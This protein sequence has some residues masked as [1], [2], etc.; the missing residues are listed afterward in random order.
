MTPAQR[1]AL[2]LRHL[3]QLARA[4]AELR[5]A[6]A[7]TL[8]ALQL[9]YEAKDATPADQQQATTQANDDVDAQWLLLLLLLFGRR[10]DAAGGAK[11]RRRAAMQEYAARARPALLAVVHHFIEG[12]RSGADPGELVRSTSILV[13]RTNVIQAYN[14]GAF[15]GVN[16]GAN[17]DATKTWLS[18][19]DDR[20]RPTHKVADGQTVALTAKFHVGGFTADYPGDPSLPA[21]E[22][23]NCRCVLIVHEAPITAGVMVT[24]PD[25]LPN[26]WEGV[27]APIGRPTG[28]GRMLVMPETG[29][30]HRMYP[31]SFTLQHVSEGVDVPIGTIEESWIATV[32]G[33]QGE[34][35]MGRGRLDLGSEAGAEYARRLHEGFADTQSIQPDEVTMETRFLN[36]EGAIVSYDEATTLDADGFDVLRDG[37]QAVMAMTDWRLASTAAVSIPAFD[38]ARISPVYDYVP[39]A[40]AE[41]QLEAEF[42]ALL[43]KRKKMGKRWP[44]YEE[45]TVQEDGVEPTPDAVVA[46]VVGGQVFNREFFT[47][48]EL[49]GPTPLTV[50]PDGHV[51][52]HVALF[53]TCYMAPGGKQGCLTPPRGNDYS[54]FATHSAWLGDDEFIPVGMITF[55]QG[56]ST[57]GSLRASQA[58]YANI[59]TGAAKVVVG[60]DQWGVWVSG[61]V[62]EEFAPRAY[63]LLLSPLSGHWEPDLDRGGKLTL[64]AAHVVVSPG[65]HVPRVAAS[66]TEDG[67]VDLVMT[68]G[69]ALVASVPGGTSSLPI[70]DTG[71][72]WDGGAAAGRIFDWAT[73]PDGG[74]DEGKASKGFLWVDGDGSLRGDYKFP[75][76]DVIGG[77]LTL[78]PRGV[79][80]AAGRAGQAKGVD[81]AAIKAKICSLYARI[82][83]QDANW[84]DCPFNKAALDAPETVEVPLDRDPRIAFAQLRA[85]TALK[86]L[87]LG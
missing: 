62:L 17:P 52:G 63:D 8:L 18:L 80:A 68:S 55:G 73:E 81:T 16:Y 30:R 86:K 49:D 1:R 75:V 48:P 57:A 53:G 9:R 82:Q 7:A 44:S 79:S 33:A 25:A 87:G 42:T 51:F 34:F 4:E 74:L 40:E 39:P 41:A 65:Y 28:D 61:E 3:A 12:L 35:L 56:H 5:A 64:I 36:S 67:E 71:R 76:A 58:Q 26:G 24:T 37:Y 45:F 66:F 10:Y 50:T 78:I 47:T 54:R 46:A 31:M 29:Y 72:A 85:K 15:K 83:K 43:A 69:P 13:A 59:A 60:E 23:C 6:V 11:A 20:V 21:S 70:A 2:Q 84:P 38:E 22:A 32:D 19:R 77:T 27:M 14:G